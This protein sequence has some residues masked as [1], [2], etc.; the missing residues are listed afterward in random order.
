MP[1]QLQALEITSVVI[2][3]W[4]IIVGA[5]GW[6]FG[7]W[8][9]LALRGYGMCSCVRCDSKWQLGGATRQVPLGNKVRSVQNAVRNSLA[10]CDP[11]A[12]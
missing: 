4:Y 9:V 8:R 11:A 2:F 10:S 12:V 6:R 7:S 1:S 5:R 3:S